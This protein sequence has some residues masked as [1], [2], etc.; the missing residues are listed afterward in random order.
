MKTPYS[1][2]SAGEFIGQEVS[3]GAW[4]PIE[5]QRINQ[6]AECTGDRQ[7]IHV[8]PERCAKESPFGVPIAHGFLTLS[9]I[10]AAVMEGG[11]IPPD[12][13][14]VI[15]AG[16]N[17]VRFKTPVRVNARVRTRISLATVEPK[18]DARQLMVL[19]AQLEVEGEADPALTADV[20]LMLFR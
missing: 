6:F 20:T 17:N 16:V 13:S 12:V 14:R 15:N 4:L 3:L 10:G 1:Y 7:W 18:G 11:A 9:L 8:D 19:K 2:A 5:Q